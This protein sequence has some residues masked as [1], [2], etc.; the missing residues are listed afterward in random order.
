[1]TTAGLIFSNIHDSEMQELTNIRTMASVP[2]GCRYRLIDFP[3][4]NMVNSGITKIGIITHNNYQSLMD[5]LGTGKDWDL[6]R[7]SGGIRL[8][9]PFVNTYNPA[10][11]NTLYTSRLEALMGVSGFLARCNEDCIVMSDCDGVFNIDLSEVLHAHLEKGADMTIVTRRSLAGETGNPEDVPELSK[12]ELAQQILI[13][14]A[15]ATKNNAAKRNMCLGMGVVVAVQTGKDEVSKLE[16]PVMTDEVKRDSNLY[17]SYRNVAEKIKAEVHRVAKQENHEKHYDRRRVHTVRLNRHDRNGIE[18]LAYN[19]AGKHQ[20]H[21]SR[22]A[23]NIAEPA[24]SRIVD[25]AEGRRH[26]AEAL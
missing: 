7:R 18:D 8:L 17:K 15:Q 20:S 9:P 12:R 19:A 26:L 6:A 13:N 2:F 5:H 14:P 25:A 3:L 22:I 1:M 11:V 4:S 10:S 21:Y 24:G 16:I 23:E